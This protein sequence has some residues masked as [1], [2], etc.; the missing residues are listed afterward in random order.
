[1]NCLWR[2]T[3]KQKVLATYDWGQALMLP[4]NKNLSWKGPSS[5][6]FFSCYESTLSSVGLEPWSWKSTHCHTIFVGR[7]GRVMFQ[8]RLN[9]ATGHGCYHVT[10]VHNNVMLQMSQMSPLKWAILFLLALTLEEG[11]D[12]FDDNLCSTLKHWYFLCHLAFH[13]RWVLLCCRLSVLN[14]CFN[15]FKDKPSK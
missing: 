14:G 13:P 15:D 12:C 10:A 8:N 4:N 9:V 5:G 1:M 3:K 6:E 11:V 7:Q 2:K